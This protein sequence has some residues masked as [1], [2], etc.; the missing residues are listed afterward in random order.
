VAVTIFFIVFSAPDLAITQ[1]LIEVLTVVLLVLVF[2]R[3]KPDVA[4]SGLACAGAC[5]AAAR[6]PLSVGIVR[7]WHR[8]DQPPGAGGAEHLALLPGEL[9]CRSARAAMW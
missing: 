2:F 8:A 1:L 6:W 7:L 3:V 5:Y 4:D 9:R